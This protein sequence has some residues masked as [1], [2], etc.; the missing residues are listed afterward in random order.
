MELLIAGKSQC[1]SSKNGGFIARKRCYDRVIWKKF[2]TV[3]IIET[4]LII[5]HDLKVTL[6]RYL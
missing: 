1:K 4:V 2:Q 3:L 5:F 6:V